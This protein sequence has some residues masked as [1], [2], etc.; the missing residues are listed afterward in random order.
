VIPIGLLAMAGLIFAAYKLTGGGQDLTRVA[1]GTGLPLQYVQLAAKEARAN[2]VPLEWVLATIIVESKGNPNAQGDADKRSVGLMQVNVVAHAKDVTR[3]QMLDPAQNIAWG[4]R[5]LAQFKQD[6]LAA[7]GGR[8]PPAAL[9]ELTRLAYKGP[10]TVKNT[11]RAGGNPLKL[12]WA[13]A[14]INNWRQAM[15][16]VRAAMGMQTIRVFS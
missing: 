15:A 1:A 14:A 13:R 2:G 9:D 11:L 8:T 10:T 12:S 5:Y 16:T 6:V 3:A 4:T 7:I